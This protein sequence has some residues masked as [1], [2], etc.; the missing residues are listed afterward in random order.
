MVRGKINRTNKAL[1]DWADILTE[2]DEVST[3][4]EDSGWETLV[5]HPGDVATTDAAAASDSGFRLLVPDSEL[6]ALESTVSGPDAVFDQFEVYRARDTNVRIFVVVV[7]SEKTMEA[8][9]YPVFYDSDTDHSFVETLRTEPEIRT[10]VSD[11]GDTRR[12][13]F[14]HTEPTLFLPQ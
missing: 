10:T 2:I 11:L 7:K 8:V 6:E 5:L 13:S 3:E 9:L 14:R 12:C 4:L 1:A